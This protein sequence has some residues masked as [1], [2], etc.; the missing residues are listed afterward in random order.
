MR[1]QKT[2]KGELNIISIIIYFYDVVCQIFSSCLQNL[3][4]IY[5]FCHCDSL[6]CIGPEPIRVSMADCNK[7]KLILFLGF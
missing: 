3:S 1:K 6:N 4:K 5:F 2:K 7:Y